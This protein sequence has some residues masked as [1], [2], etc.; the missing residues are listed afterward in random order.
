MTSVNERRIDRFLSVVLI[1]MVL[2]VSVVTIFVIVSPKEKERDSSRKLK[3]KVADGSSINTFAETVQKPASEGT[4]KQSRFS[5]DYLDAVNILNSGNSCERE[6]R[7]FKYVIE[8]EGSS[9]RI[10]IPPGSTLESEL[11][12]LLMNFGFIDKIYFK[13]FSEIEW[14]AKVTHGQKIL[15]SIK[16]FCLKVKTSGFYVLKITAVAPEPTFKA[17]YMIC[18]NS[19][20]ECNLL[21]KKDRGE[22]D[23]VLDNLYMYERRARGIQAFYSQLSKINGSKGHWIYYMET[24]LVVLCQRANVPM[25]DQQA[26]MCNI[27][28]EKLHKNMWKCSAHVQHAWCKL[29][30]EHAEKTQMVHSCYYCNSSISLESSKPIIKM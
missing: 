29:Q 26:K 28:C 21:P 30:K 1:L 13:E 22:D 10:T 20:L 4:P 7:R 12:I 25:T 2:A 14:L 27:L 17:A 11:K 5:L 19:T 8:F 9:P 15:S 24:E 18:I 16:K 6:F 23:I 3:D